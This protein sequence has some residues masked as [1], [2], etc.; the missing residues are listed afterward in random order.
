MLNLWRRRSQEAKSRK[1]KNFLFG[2]SFKFGEGRV[3]RDRILADILQSNEANPQQGLR[4]RLTLPLAPNSTQKDTQLQ[5]QSPL[6]FKL[7]LE[8][9]LVIYERVFGG[10][11]IHFGAYPEFR[12]NCGRGEGPGY[13]YHHAVCQQELLH[14]YICHDTMCT[15]Y[16]ATSFWRTNE[17]LPP[18]SRVDLPLLRSCRRV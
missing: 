6:F 9:R 15:D 5:M 16:L 2:D 14:S 13:G 18:S 1:T 3:Y 10:Q 8:I 7:P 11:K 4:R 17:L 12:Q